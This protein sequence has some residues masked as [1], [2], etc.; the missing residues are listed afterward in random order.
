[1]NYDKNFIYREDI[2]EFNNSNIYQDVF[3]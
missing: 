2:P 1:L 3:R